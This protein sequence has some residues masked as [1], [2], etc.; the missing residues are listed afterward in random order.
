MLRTLSASAAA[1]LL[2]TGLA[3][4]Q[5]QQTTNQEKT[6]VQ[7]PDGSQSVQA[8]K[9]QSTRD[10]SGNQTTDQKSYNR[11]DSPNGSQENRSSEQRTTAPDGSSATTQQKSTTTKSPE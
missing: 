4:A 9:S 5:D 7:N 11:T 10:G 1:L 8:N 2:M 3:T 6:T